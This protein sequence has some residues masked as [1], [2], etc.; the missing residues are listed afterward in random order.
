METAWL[1]YPN[2]SHLYSVPWI[3]VLKIVRDQSIRSYYIVTIAPKGHVTANVFM[4]A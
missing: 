4:V 2:Q 1:K 3:F